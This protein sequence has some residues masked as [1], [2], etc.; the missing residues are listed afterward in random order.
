MSV[1][2]DLR[3]V[4]WCM[5]ARKKETEPGLGASEGGRA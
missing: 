1:D 5:G 2:F 3:N 4:G